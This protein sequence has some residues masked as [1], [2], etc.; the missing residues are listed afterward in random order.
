MVVSKSHIWSTCRPHVALSILTLQAQSSQH[1]QR[2]KPHTPTEQS[3]QH[4]PPLPSRLMLALTNRKHVC[5]LAVMAPA[6]IMASHSAW[7]L[8]IW[9]SSHSSELQWIWFIYTLCWVIVFRSL[10]QYFWIFLEVQL[11]QFP[12]KSAV[13]ICN[14]SN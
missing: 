8:H 10:F 9:A 2:I 3:R 12:S 5:T 14:K 1:V 11:F 4:P 6:L 13:Y 7:L